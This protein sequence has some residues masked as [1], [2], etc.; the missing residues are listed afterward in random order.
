M[1]HSQKIKIFHSAFW[2]FLIYKYTNFKVDLCFNN[3]NTIL[4]FLVL[5]SKD[6]FIVTDG[7]FLWHSQW[8]LKYFCTLN[9]IAI[10]H[11]LIEDNGGGGGCG[12][13]TKLKL[14]I[15]SPYI[16]HLTNSTLFVWFQEN[17]PSGSF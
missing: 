6:E 7:V 8:A 5:S 4:N 11:T 12:Q 15:I 16:S 9:I 13:I 17:R 1:F 14:F 3:A 2:L 10:M